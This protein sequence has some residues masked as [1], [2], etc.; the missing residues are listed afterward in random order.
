MAPTES[1]ACVPGGFHS[2]I[3]GHCAPSATYRRW[4][5]HN[6]AVVSFDPKCLNVALMTDAS[7]T[8]GAGLEEGGGLTG[9]MEIP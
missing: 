6:L 9:D 8:E 7:L 1:S 5:L 4:V 3:Q 2:E